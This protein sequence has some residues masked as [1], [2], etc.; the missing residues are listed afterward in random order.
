MA[1][2]PPDQK[3]DQEALLRHFREAFA[4]DPTRAYSEWYRAQ[5]ELRDGGP[6]EVARA[7]A[8]DFWSLLD[9]LPFSSDVE[10]ARF[11]HNVA[12]FF[13]S[14][15]P[16]ADLGRA[17]R[18]FAEALDHFSSDDDAGWRARA[19]H[20]FATALANLGET[21]ETLEEAVSLFE[22]ALA[23]RTSER[24]IARGVSLH[25]L[26]RALHRWADLDP[27]RS[28]KL[29]ERSAAAFTEAAEIRRRHGLN[30][31]RALS[32]FQSGLALGALGRAAAAREALESAAEEFDRLGKSG[33]AAIA[34][35]R[36]QAN[37]SASAPD[38]DTETDTD[39][40][41][42]FE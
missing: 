40:D 19:H 17:R 22:R 35:A 39:T 3:A 7:L 33:S 31:G 6:P 2:Q 1:G 42:D 37:A 34:L 21:P 24:E 10:R 38:P 26:G 30:E 18:L 36:A 15:G 20:N 12:V 16:A 29:L 27:P 8:E 5:E 23:W 28:R 25:N 32:L 9:G 11:R 41:T 13:G 4:A 14:A